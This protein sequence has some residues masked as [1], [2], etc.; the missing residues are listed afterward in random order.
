MSS[1]R[2][3]ELIAVALIVILFGIGVGY[4]TSLINVPRAY[5]RVGPTIF[6]YAVGVLLVGLGLLL[7]RDA[8]TGRWFCEA[9]DP[10][11]PAPD[12]KP[13]GWVLGAFVV[14]LLLIAQVGFILSST[15]SFVMVAKAFGAKRIW[16][17]ALVGFI[18]AIV[19]YYGFARLLGLRMGGGIIE[20][21]I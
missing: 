9:T 7:L 11:T 2:S 21:F 10:E 18:L 3:K 1:L 19:A 8:M 16:L 5:T 14:N 13:V 6:P 15:A 12:M 20:D 17:A 4:W